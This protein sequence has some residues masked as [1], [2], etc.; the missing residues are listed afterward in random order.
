MT[1]HGRK[2]RTLPLALYAVMSLASSTAAW[3]DAQP[4]PFVLT[5]Y[6]SAPGG[7]DLLT[8]RYPAALQQLRASGHAP[9]DAAAVSANNCVA[10]AMTR[11]WDAAQSACDAAVREARDARL[12]AAPW[13]AA[14]ANSKDRAIA[15]AYSDRAV[16]RWMSGNA[17]GARADLDEA[18]V[19]APQAGFVV[20]NVRAL[21][22]QA[23]KKVTHGS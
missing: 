17:R 5:A 10:L 2:L 7:Q 14:G 19:F 21:R 3:A 9:L 16:L 15:A 12:S 1:S 6:G 13:S 22:A 18:R 20:R 4:H 23:L 8:G 11:R